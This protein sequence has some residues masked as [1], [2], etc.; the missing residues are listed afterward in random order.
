[1]RRS[2]LTINLS[3]RKHGTS[4]VLLAKCTDYLKGFSHSMHHIDLHHNLDN[5]QLIFDAVCNADT[6]I[7]SGPCY[8]NTYPA[9]TVRLLE[10]LAAHPEIILHDQKIYAIIQGGMPYAHTHINGLNMLSVFASK[11]NVSYHGGFVMGLGAALDGQ[12]L[13]KLPNGKKVERQL[14]VFCEHI[15]NGTKSPDSVYENALLKVPRVVTWLLAKRMN[16][17]I[18]KRFEERGI[19]VYTPSPYIMDEIK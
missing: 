8:V 15:H 12:S 7:F 1:M 6:L 16:K 13:D 14:N 18:N 17:M 5:F 3:P 19:D 10:E 9:D 11:V 4:S 2:I